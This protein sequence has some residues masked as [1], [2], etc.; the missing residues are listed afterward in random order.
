MTLLDGTL[1]VR[2]FHPDGFVGMVEAD[3]QRVRVAALACEGYDTGDAE[4]GGL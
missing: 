3:G 1:P 2:P 4:S